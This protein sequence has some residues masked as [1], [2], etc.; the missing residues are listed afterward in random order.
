MEDKIYEEIK[1]KDTESI[2]HYMKTLNIIDDNNKVEYWTS[3]KNIDFIIILSNLGLVENN[4]ENLKKLD[5]FFE[6]LFKLGIESGLCTSRQ[7][8]IDSIKK[9]KIDF[10]KLME[11][12]PNSYINYNFE[13]RFISDMKEA[14]LNDK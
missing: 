3:R 1:R 6:Y 7:L 11:I 4:D 10:D 14:I 8:M 2:R 9:G 12:D 5:E 13:P